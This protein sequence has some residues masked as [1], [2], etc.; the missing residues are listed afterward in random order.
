[1]VTV[2]CSRKEYPLTQLAV[3]VTTS[4]YSSVIVVEASPFAK[5]RVDSAM[6]AWVPW[7]RD[8]EI[9]SLLRGSM[10]PDSSTA[11]KVRTTVSPTFAVEGAIRVSFVA[12]EGAGGMDGA[13]IWYTARSTRSV[14]K[15]ARTYSMRMPGCLC[16][17]VIDQASDVG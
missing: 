16:F 8:S 12:P 15:I 1:M 11:L 5:V 10:F 17:T 14:M 13:N 7:F 6:V 3:T 4:A 9:V 2:E